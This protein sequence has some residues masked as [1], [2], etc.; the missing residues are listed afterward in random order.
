M[1]RAVYKHASALRISL[2]QEFLDAP[3]LTFPRRPGEGIKMR[4][5]Y[6]ARAHSPLAV[7]TTTDSIKTSRLSAIREALAQGAMRHA[8]RLV[9]SMHPAEIASLLESLP[10]ARREIVW[11]FVDPE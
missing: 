3:I 1:I 4:F 10:P 5:R 9:N 2:L 6:T 7:M 8:N 11:E